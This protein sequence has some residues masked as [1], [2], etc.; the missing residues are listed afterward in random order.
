MSMFVCGNKPLF[1]K[2]GLW[3]K[4]GQSA[5]VYIT[6]FWI[7]VPPVTMICTWHL[8]QRKQTNGEETP[9]NPDIIVIFQALG[10]TKCFFSP[11]ATWHGGRSSSQKN[12]GSIHYVPAVFQTVWN[13]F[14]F[15]L[16]VQFLLLPPLIFGWQHFSFCVSFRPCQQPLDSGS[17][18]FIRGL[19]SKWISCKRF[20]ECFWF[21]VVKCDF[22]FCYVHDAL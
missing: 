7:L 17:T 13:V 12:S 19:I 9:H 15:L 11:V 16:F 10:I 8:H 6:L 5:I 1:T 21:F 22:R 2:T 3:V 20:T 14:L 18:F 4:F